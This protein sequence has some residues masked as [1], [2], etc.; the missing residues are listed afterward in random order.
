[1]KATSNR[2]L[3]V[4]RL[5]AALFRASLRA[6]ARRSLLGH[7][8]LFIPA[9]VACLVTGFLR[10]RGN[11]NFD[12]PGMPYVFFVFAGMSFWQ[13]FVD[14]LG[15]PLAQHSQN[16]SIVSRIRFPHEALTLAGLWN[17][18]LNAAVRICGVLILCAVVGVHVGGSIVWLPL[19]VLALALLG[20]GLGLLLTPL[21]LLYDDIGRALPMATTL[22]FFVMPVAYPLAATGW[23]AF[24]PVL[25]LINAARASIVGASVADPLWL[26]LVVGVLAL[27]VAFPFYRIAQPELIERMG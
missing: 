26:P 1:M 25:P 13:V 8:W 10:N 12:V 9:L 18:L 20:L 2:L 19:A 4:L 7:L 27:A 21:G 5:S 17:V 3:H 23:E 24:N 16:R 14:A 22:L 15:A 6:R 11:L